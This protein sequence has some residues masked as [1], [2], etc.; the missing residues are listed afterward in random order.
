MDW[1]DQG[2]FFNS[3]SALCTIVLFL[4]NTTKLHSVIVMASK[5]KPMQFLCTEYVLKN[6]PKLRLTIKDH[7]LKPILGLT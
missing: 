5:S 4:T 2:F 1:T 7:P 3:L 6:D